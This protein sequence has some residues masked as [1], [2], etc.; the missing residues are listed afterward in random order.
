MLPLEWLHPSGTPLVPDCISL[1]GPQ[2][3]EVLSMLTSWDAARFQATEREPGQP[4]LSVSWAFPS[5]P[6]L[7]R[8]GSPPSHSPCLGLHPS[9]CHP[10][11]SPIPPG[12]HL[13]FD[14]WAPSASEEV[15]GSHHYW[16][17]SGTI[18]CYLGVLVHT[19]PRLGVLAGG[20]DLGGLGV[21]APLPGGKS[22]RELWPNL[23][24]VSFP[25]SPSLPTFFSSFLSLLN[26]FIEM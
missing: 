16:L 15:R 4:R 9:S 6:H 26:S 22:Q 19:F 2:L 3:Q 24:V 11:P 12:P 13:L 18:T 20:G 5:E 1:R 23:C 25:P 7:C 10:R 8:S 14:S 17:E 21:R